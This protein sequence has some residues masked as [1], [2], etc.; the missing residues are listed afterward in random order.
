MFIKP[1]YGETKNENEILQLDLET[2]KSVVEVLSF[3]QKCFE[4]AKM[5][6]I[7]SGFHWKSSQRSH[8]P[9]IRWGKV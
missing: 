3:H 9:L 6:A 5:H 2:I 4:S 1:E 8:K 7:R